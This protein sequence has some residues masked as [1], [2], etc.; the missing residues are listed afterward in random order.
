MGNPFDKGGSSNP[1]APPDPNVQIAAET[2]ANRYNIDSPFGQQSWSTGGDR[3]ITGYDKNGKPIYGQ[4]QTLTQSL[5]PSQQRQFDIRNQIAEQ[6]LAQ[7]G[8]QV[9]TARPGYSALPARPGE[10]AGPRLPGSMGTFDIN[11]GGNEAGKAYFERQKAF[12]EPEFAKADN[13][14]AQDLANQ[15]IPMGSPA[16]TEAMRDHENNKNF[17]LT[18]AS[19]EATTMGSDLALRERGQQF[20]ERSQ[21]SDEALATSADARAGRGQDFSQYLNERGQTQGMDIDRRQQYYNEIASLLGGQQ[22]TPLDGGGTGPVDVGSA[23]AAQ[24]AAE[25]DAYNARTGTN[26][27]MMSGLFGL[28]SAAIGQWCERFMKRAIRHVYTLADG[29]RVY[30]FKYFGSARDHMGPMADEVAALRP[31]AIVHDSGLRR[32]NLAAL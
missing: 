19:R 16:F 24:Q 9:G 6:M 30:L 4:Q 5:D 28:G 29:L 22:L 15:G 8:Q 27:S 13:R 10:R 25:R 12:L 11:T 20:G 17:A 23:Y 31:W 32:V 2:A 14:F 21:L 18:Q 3:V 26:N 1:P 7:G